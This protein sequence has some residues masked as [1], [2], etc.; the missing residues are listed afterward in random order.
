MISHWSKCQ[1]TIAFSSGE[2]ELNAIVK[3]A[4]EMIGV[5]EL[6]KA[7]GI[8]TKPVMY[9]DASAARGMILRKG[10]GKIKHLTTKQVWVQAAVKEYNIDSLRLPRDE[11]VA[12]M[13][14]HC[15][16]QKAFEGHLQRLN[17]QR[18]VKDDARSSSRG[19][20]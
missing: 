2:A 13:F 12:D 15:T 1:A 16:T 5:R 8:T 3:G 20:V 6:M 7:I 17:I 19:G 4:S 11:N 10:A 14:T 18:D 9:T